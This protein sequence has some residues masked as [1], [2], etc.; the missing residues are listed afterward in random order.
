[1]TVRPSSLVLVPIVLACLLVLG[2]AAAMPQASAASAPIR[3]YR[4][5]G[6]WFDMWDY[7]PSTWKNPEI[8]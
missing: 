5:L 1:M 3:A 4:G 2:T 6:T 8:R 7:S